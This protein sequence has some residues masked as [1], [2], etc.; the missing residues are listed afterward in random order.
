[1]RLNQINTFYNLL[2]QIELKFP[3]RSLGELLNLRRNI[4]T[5]GVYFFFDQFEIRDQYIQERVVRIGTH[6]A[7]ANSKAT[8]KQRIA[9]HK[10]PENLYG[11]HRNSVFREL[12]G[13]AL[14]N[15]NNLNFNHWGVRKE[16]SNKHVISVEREFEKEISLYLRSLKFT[17]LEIPGDASKDNDRAFIERNTIALLSNY[18]RTVIDAPSCNWLGKHT[19]KD[20]I[21]HSGL[22]NSNYVDIKSVE[23]DYFDKMKFYIEKMKYYC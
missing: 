13:Y 15:K 19:G 2:Q 5:Q 14:I 9:Q 8:I 12:V 21:I 22:W 3:K 10:G 20:K 18:E 11:Q 7:Q 1:M 23:S 16:K 4:P 17:I 6:A